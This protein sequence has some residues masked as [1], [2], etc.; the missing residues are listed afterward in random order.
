M[1]IDRTDEASYEEAIAGFSREALEATL[2]GDLAR[3]Q[4]PRRMLRPSCG[5][6][7]SPTGRQLVQTSQDKCLPPI[8]ML[9][10]I[11]LQIGQPAQ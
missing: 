5:A 11:Q 4:R 8:G 7:A 6:L 9:V 3:R 10:V 1:T 2:A